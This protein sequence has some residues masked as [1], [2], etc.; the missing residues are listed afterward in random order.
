MYVI[1]LYV[2]TLPEVIYNI[3]TGNISISS[4]KKIKLPIK[5][6]PVSV[7]FAIFDK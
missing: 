2:V 5:A 6:L 1:F 3:E 7:T 4:V